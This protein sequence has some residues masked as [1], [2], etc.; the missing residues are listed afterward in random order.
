VPDRASIFSLMV[1]THEAT[2]TDIPN[3]VEGKKLAPEASTEL[4]V[5][6]SCMCTVTFQLEAES[7][8]W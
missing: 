2:R 1:C 4:N 8:G 3:M 7:R 5:T 6:S